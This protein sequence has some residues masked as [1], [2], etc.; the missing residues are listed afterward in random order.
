MYSL[1]HL[2]VVPIILAYWKDGLEYIGGIP[3]P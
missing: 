2:L 1:E 3:V